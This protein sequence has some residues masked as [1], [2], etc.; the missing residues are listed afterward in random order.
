MADMP[1]RTAYHRSLGWH[2]ADMSR[3]LTVGIIGAIGALVLGPFIGWGL[4]VVT[5][6]D[7]VAVTFLL[8]TWPI[9]ARADGTQTRHMAVREDDT[10]GTARVLLLGASV[11]S[12]AGAGFALERAGHATGAVQVLLIALAVLTVVLSWTLVNTVYTLRYAHI[13]FDRPGSG[14]DFEGTGEDNPPTYRDFAYAAFTIGMCYQVSDTT[15]RDGATRGTA[16]SHALL[17]Y[18][19]GVVIVA[20]V[21]NLIGGLVH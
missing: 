16:L 13:E 15:M 20:G 11:G 12:L 17:S 9:I 7:C 2:A 14:I 4:G 18:L 10:R 6:W 21:I 8:S 3:T 19:F 1:P 5:G